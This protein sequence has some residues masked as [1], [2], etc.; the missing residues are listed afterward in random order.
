MRDRCRP[1]L[2][3]RFIRGKQLTEEASRQS[4]VMR[5]VAEMLRT[6]RDDPVLE[7]LDVFSPFGAMHVD[8]PPHYVSHGRRFL[9]RFLSAPAGKKRTPYQPKSPID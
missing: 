6:D 2:V 9:D 8:T 3:T 7:A 4:V 1:V 5:R